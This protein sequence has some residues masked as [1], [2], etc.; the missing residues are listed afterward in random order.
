MKK[1]LYIYLIIL[2]PLILEA[3]DVNETAMGIPRVDN[4]TSI[5]GEAAANT[6]NIVYNNADNL[7]YRYNGTTWV[8]LENA[9]EVPLVTN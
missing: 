3:Q 2:F 5:T 1:I 8:V 9:A 4:V 7:I 6:G